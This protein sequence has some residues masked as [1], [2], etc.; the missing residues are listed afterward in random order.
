MTSSSA[1]HSDLPFN[2]ALPAVMLPQ[3]IHGMPQK[4]HSVCTSLQIALQHRMFSCDVASAYSR[5]TTKVT[6]SIHTEVLSVLAQ[7]PPLLYIP[8]LL[9][10]FFLFLDNIIP[11]QG[12][13]IYLTRLKPL[14]IQTTTLYIFIYRYSCR[15]SLT[16]CLLHVSTVRSCTFST[17]SSDLVRLCHS[18]CLPPLQEQD[19]CSYHGPRCEHADNHHPQ[20][21]GILT[22]NIS[23]PK[24]PKSDTNILH[25][26]EFSQPS[27]G[28]VSHDLLV[29]D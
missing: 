24:S 13:E 21:S 26:A 3:H 4:G 16:Q 29:H 8:T 23:A 17:R 10:S 19:C 25:Q 6:E 20:V 7:R 27:D 14:H 12:L 15:R 9:P 18:R 11:K 22:F 1:H 5:N 2:T 28:C